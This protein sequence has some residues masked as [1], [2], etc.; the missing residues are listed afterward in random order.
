MKESTKVKGDTLN[1]D[2][3]LKRRVQFYWSA[4]VDVGNFKT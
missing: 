4:D 2:W 1:V 3:L